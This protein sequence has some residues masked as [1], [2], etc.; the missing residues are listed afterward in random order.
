[1]SL[2]AWRACVQD[3]YWLANAA[4]CFLNVV[5]FGIRASICRVQKNCDQRGGRNHLA[6]E[7]P[8]CFPS[9][10]LGEHVHTS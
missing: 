1:M 2:P 9:T 3:M 5:E 8:N 10:T 7:F 4:R 6:Q